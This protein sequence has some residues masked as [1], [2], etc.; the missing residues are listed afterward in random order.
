M[1]YLATFYTHLG[2]IEFLHAVSREDT[3]VRM[4]PVPR[5]LSAS[6]GV[7]VYFSVPFAS[8]FCSEDLEAVYQVEG[9][10]YQELYRNEEEI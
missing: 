10:N 4:A 8:T 6:C 3:S 5:V 1:S 7:C 9:H 2:A